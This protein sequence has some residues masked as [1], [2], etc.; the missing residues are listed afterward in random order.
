MD[1]Q[2]QRVFGANGKANA[3]LQMF[4]LGGGKGGTGAPAPPA[5]PAKQKL[6]KGNP[7]AQGP[8]PPTAPRL[9]T[10]SFFHWTPLNW[11]DGLRIHSQ[12][13]LWGLVHGKASIIFHSCP[14]A[15]DLTWQWAKEYRLDVEPEGLTVTPSRNVSA[16]RKILLP[17]LQS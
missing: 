8:N 11:S 17:P 1:Q 13:G 15:L 7:E 12:N 9:Q 16:G 5:L 4:S 10:K 14:F 6:K 3:V 2:C